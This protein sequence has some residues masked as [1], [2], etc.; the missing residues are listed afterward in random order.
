MSINF[1]GTLCIVIYGFYCLKT[2]QF[3]C[4]ALMMKALRENTYVLARLVKHNIHVPYAHPAWHCPTTCSG[5]DINKI[6]FP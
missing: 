3:L 2:V 4:E 1:K 5:Y 6:L